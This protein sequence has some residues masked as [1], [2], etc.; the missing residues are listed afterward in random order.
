MF[1]STEQDGS[2][3][4][5]EPLRGRITTTMNDKLSSEFTKEEIKTTLFQMHPTKAPGLDSMLLFYQKYQYLVGEHVT[6][7]VLKVL[8]SGNFLVWFNHIFITL[9]PKKE[10]VMKVVNFCPISIYNVLYKIVAKV[11]A[12]RLKLILP[13]MISRT[14]VILSPI[15]KSQIISW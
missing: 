6:K 1:S 3:D 2:V 8:N 5:L 7:K 11:I 15:D 12:N 13:T 4:F 10:Q 9:V 14:K